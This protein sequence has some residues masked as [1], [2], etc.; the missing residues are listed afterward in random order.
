MG[1]NDVILQGG[2]EH[3]RVVLDSL[4][5]QG[6]NVIA[7]FDPKFSGT[8]FGV[9][10]R[11]A[12]DRSFRADAHAIVAIGDNALRK[13]VVGDTIHRFTST[14]HP[15]VVMSPFAEV[16]VGSMVLHGAIIQAQARV[17]EHVIVNTGAQVDHDCV[18]ADFVHLAPGV[19]LCGTVQVGQG[20]FVGAGA[21]IIPGK[22]V[23]AWATVGAGAVV[24]KD[25]PDYAVVVGNPARVIK[26]NT[27]PL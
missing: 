2:G 14:V 16:G 4:L 26:Y 22:K 7:L 24:V 18:L 17:G 25:V 3:A 9:P 15:S 19:I 11:G 5:A 8:L 27:P 6:A 10:Q 12:Y 13:R 20:A 23:G 1:T 21:T